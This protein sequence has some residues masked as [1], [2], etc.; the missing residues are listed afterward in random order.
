[1]VSTAAKAIHAL[2]EA[3][4]ALVEGVTGVSG[5][6]SGILCLSPWGRQAGRS[7]MSVLVTGGAK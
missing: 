6:A 4:H 3:I 7:N 1:M 2:V 5:T